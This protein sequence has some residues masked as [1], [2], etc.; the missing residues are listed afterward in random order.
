MQAL[1]GRDQGT[2]DLRDRN[3]KVRIKTQIARP[4]ILTVSIHLLTQ[5]LT[6]KCI[7]RI[8]NI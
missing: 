1:P 8:N 2:G 7:H 6:I 4:S 5:A 3:T